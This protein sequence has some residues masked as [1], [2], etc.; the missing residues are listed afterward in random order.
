VATS[1]QAWCFMLG[2]G[3]RLGARPFQRRL[4]TPLHAAKMASR[5]CLGKEAYS[6]PPSTASITTIRATTRMATVQNNV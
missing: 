3:G 5:R 4:G 2:P 6:Q 1:R